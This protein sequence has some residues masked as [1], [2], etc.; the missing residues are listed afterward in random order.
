[1]ILINQI[2]NQNNYK[3][4]KLEI[5]KLN[6]NDNDKFYYIS[7]IILLLLF[8]NKINIT[9]NFIYSLLIVL[10]IIYIIYQYQLNFNNKDEELDY[11][12]SFLDNESYFQDYKSFVDLLYNI[13]DFPNKNIYKD[14]INKINNF[15][16][17]YDEYDNTKDNIKIDILKDISLNIFNTYNSYIFN[18]PTKYD[19]E[20]QT[21]MNLLYKLLNKY[22]DEIIIYS[23]K[24]SSLNNKSIINNKNDV[25]YVYGE[26]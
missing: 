16:I 14:L 10:G 9:T 19:K 4:H 17:Y 23:N 20:Y 18:L 12:N 8:L 3:E 2:F 5:P 1:M 24:K 15:L 25:F 11:I 22:L 7:L 21:N 6:L 13:K 26:E